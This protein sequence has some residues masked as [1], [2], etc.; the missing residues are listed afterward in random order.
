MGELR[1]GLSALSSP[2]GLLHPAEGFMGDSRV[3]L[4]VSVAQT[5]L[6]WLLS[7][8]CGSALGIPHLEVGTQQ[9]G[10]LQVW[11]MADAHHSFLKELLDYQC[12]GNKTPAPQPGSFK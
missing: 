7:S 10:I 4:K 5:S 2:Q 8:V 3:R 1:C 6:G 11:A 9:L 12:S